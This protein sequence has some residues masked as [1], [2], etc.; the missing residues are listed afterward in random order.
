MGE[1]CIN[2]QSKSN[3]E[4]QNDAQSTLTP[5]RISESSHSSRRHDGINEEFLKEMM[6]ELNRTE[7]D[8]TTVLILNGYIISKAS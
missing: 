5:R 6:I 8:L 1:T 2:R 3:L 4:I 7:L